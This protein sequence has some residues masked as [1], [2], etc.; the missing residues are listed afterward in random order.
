MST[1]HGDSG[2]PVFR[3]LALY[4]TRRDH[5]P[6]P[7]LRPLTGTPAAMVHNVSLGAVS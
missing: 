6:V 7:A 4:T 2:Y 3:S 1:V 5:V